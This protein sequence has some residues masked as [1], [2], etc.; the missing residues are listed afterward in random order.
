MNIPRYL[1]LFASLLLLC[2]VG[3]LAKARNEHSMHISDVVQLGRTRLEPGTYKV[4]WQRPGPAVNVEFLKGGKVMATAKG[5]LETNV[6]TLD[7]DDVI[8]RETHG[9]QVLERIDFAHQKESLL[10]G[11]HK[12]RA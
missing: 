4:E 2:P 8:V 11:Q 9:N 3:A 1:A 7:H 10:F 5:T 12:P 6:R